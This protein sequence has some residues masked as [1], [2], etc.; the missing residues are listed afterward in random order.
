[1]RKRW[2]ILG[3]VVA[4]GAF[5]FWGLKYGRDYAFPYRHVQAVKELVGVGRQSRVSDR[6]ASGGLPVRTT[7]RFEQ[8]QALGYVGTSDVEDSGR[9]RGAT[10]YAPDEVFPGYNLFTSG[11]ADEAVLM[12]LEGEV[13]HRWQLPREDVWWESPLAR[14]QRHVGWRYARATPDLSLYAVYDYLGLVKLD[15]NSRP[16]WIYRG[17]AHHGFWRQPDDTLYVITYREELIPELNPEVP[18]VADQVTLLSPEGEEIRSHSIPELLMG[19]DYAFL[20]PVVNHVRSDFSIDLLHTNS[21]QVFDGSLAD[22]SPLFAEGNVMLSIR[23]ISTIVIA[24]LEEGEV[25]WAWG[26]T[27][28]SYQHDA[29]L[30]QSGSILAFDNGLERSSVIEIDPLDR[31]FNWRLSATDRY[32]LKSRIYGAVQRLPNGNTL[33]TDSMQARALE[34]TPRAKVVWSYENPLLHEG[35][36]TVLFDM[37]RYPRR[38]FEGL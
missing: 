33:I 27:N 29:E 34:V 8:M 37:T 22:R 36:P 5:F 35:R 24:D 2:I 16:Q 19:S 23:N 38:Y 20:L 6:T 15:R 14:R 17:G 21:I 13:V 3:F 31:L 10:V 12:D 11:H 7:S 1:M 18:I 26:P 28:V 32:G 4:A 9:Q 30:L 25:L